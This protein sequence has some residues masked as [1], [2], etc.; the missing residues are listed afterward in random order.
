M[1]AVNFDDD[2]RATGELPFVIALG[3]WAR[4]NEIGAAAGTWT[5]AS[6][7][8]AGE[9][10]FPFRD[11]VAVDGSGLRHLRIGRGGAPGSWAVVDD[12][13]EVPAWSSVHQVVAFCD[14]G[15]RTTVLAVGGT[16]RARTSEPDGRWGAPWTDLM[17][18]HVDSAGTTAPVPVGPASRVTVSYEVD[19]GGFA[20]PPTV[21]VVADDG[22]LYR[23]RWN[24]ALDPSPWD[25][26]EP[27]GFA[28]APATAA[29]AV[30]GV[31][32]VRS[33][34]G[35]LWLSDT[36][37]RPFL[38]VR[39]EEVGPPGVRVRQVAAAASP[40]GVTGARVAV[41]DAS[42]ALW[43]ADARA[44]EVP[45]WRRLFPGPATGA[46]AWGHPLPARWMLLAAGV[47]GVLR[48]VAMDATGPTGPWDVVGAPA[49]D[50]PS[51]NPAAPLLAQ[52]RAA[53]QVEVFAQD[54]S[55]AIHT[56]WWS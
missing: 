38:G 55:G 2:V 5:V 43:W 4:W 8:P 14:H 27:D 20:L 19:D 25:R 44:G 56:T 10:W 11:V 37:P 17:A 30:G 24:V 35:G 16:L 41:R 42:G 12:R 47:D 34:S 23:R 28:P 49:G 26:I 40:A 51:V 45:T 21:V 54:R 1:P 46:I 7:P 33:T 29:L 18:L 15:G 48:V 6:P 31:V 36:Q 39:W 53:G 52:T 9:G 50:A 32:L 3:R 22:V 13:G